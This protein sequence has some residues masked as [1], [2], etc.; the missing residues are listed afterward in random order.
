MRI[1]IIPPSPT[2]YWTA[3]TKTLD[4]KAI[5]VFSAIGF[6]LDDETYFLEKK[7]FRPAS[8][9][10]LTDEGWKRDVY[11]SWTYEPEDVKLGEVVDRFGDLLERLVS[12]DVGAHR[13]ILPISGG[14]DSRTLLVALKGNRSVSAYSYE[15]EGG[16]RENYYGEL[17]AKKAGISHQSF[18]IP[19]GYLW[20]VIDQA[21]RTNDTE[22]EV[23]HARQLA[24]LHTLTNLGDIFLL[25][26]WGDV[27]FDGMGVP[28]DL[29]FEGQV[30]VLLKKLIKRGG[31]ELGTALW[32]SWGLEGKF[33]DYLRARVEQ[34]H[35]ILEIDNANARIR[36]FKS[37][38]WA[39]RWTG[40][41]IRFF[42]DYKPVCLP[43]FD[44][45]MCRFVCTIPEALLAGRR[46]QI[47]YIKRRWPE[48][49]KVP[50]QATRPFNLYNLHLNKHPWNIPVRIA[51]KLSM[52]LN[53]KVQRN[54][55]IQFVGRENDLHLRE[56][57]F[58]NSKLD[59]IVDRRI[60]EKY[61]DAF[62]NDALPHAFPI[63]I[64]L[65]L[66]TFA[67]HY[68]E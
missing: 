33:Y 34:L 36:A 60:R 44:D 67:K 24:W 66:S 12:R 68:L 55:E 37:T 32:Q 64:L 43:Y 49:G 2:Y 9:Y 42:S 23:V 11:F 16:I 7:T 63:S 61:Y 65:S 17:A 41:S 28:D 20:N 3:D 52:A 25:G 59:T 50:W 6:F 1:P 47:E 21:A 35:S 45:E 54:W 58:S 51:R 26:H 4:L 5:A 29:P 13:A 19:P 57:L 38:H 56:W 46:I 22:A 62:R 15:F 30:D 40:A 8:I 48:L 10:S 31:A 14:L 27:L 53:K 39:H 18:V